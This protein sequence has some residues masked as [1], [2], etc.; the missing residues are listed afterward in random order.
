MTTQ[1]RVL[2]ADDQPR[3]RRS[4]KALLG[5]VPQVAEVCEAGDGHEALRCIEACQPDLV[6]L[7]VRMPGLDGLQVTRLVKNRWPQ[8]K[9]IALSVY[10]EYGA[11]VLAAGADAFVS[12]SEP[13]HRLLEALEMVTA[14]LRQ[15]L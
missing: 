5:T 8:V 6:L 11:E 12:K 7:N 1:I 15:K 2:I 14:P 3:A 13:P 4:L 9:V 10:G